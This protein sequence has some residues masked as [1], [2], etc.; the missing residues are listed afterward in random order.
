MHETAPNTGANATKFSLW[1]QDKKDNFMLCTLQLNE[2][3]AT[4]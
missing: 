4:G 2:N 1:L 3:P